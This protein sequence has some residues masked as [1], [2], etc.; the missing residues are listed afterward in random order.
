M[1]LQTSGIESSSLNPGS[2]LRPCANVLT[3]SKNEVE[4]K[5][6]RVVVLSNDSSRRHR[7]EWST[8]IP[9]SFRRPCV[10]LAPLDGMR[11][12]EKVPS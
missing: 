10:G 9:G 8:P 6:S 5:K 2:F 4:R 1:G 12:Q 3:L 7:N 11:A